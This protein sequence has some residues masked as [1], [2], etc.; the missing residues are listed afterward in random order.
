MEFTFD[1]AYRG[2]I[3]QEIEVVSTTAHFNFK[4]NSLPATRIAPG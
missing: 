2:C 4:P 1:R 3:G